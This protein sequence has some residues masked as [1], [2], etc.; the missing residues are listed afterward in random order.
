ML[1]SSISAR[2]VLE[3]DTGHSP[4]LTAPTDLTDA[5]ERAAR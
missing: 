3:L 2:L 1:A 5:I 4:F